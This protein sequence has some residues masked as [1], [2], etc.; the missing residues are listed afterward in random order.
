MIYMALKGSERKAIKM[1]T[2]HKIAWSGLYFPIET[3]KTLQDAKSFCDNKVN[4][5][6]SIIDDFTGFR[7]YEKVLKEQL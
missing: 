6:L 3:F 7:L 5:S 1:Y 2:V 4:Y